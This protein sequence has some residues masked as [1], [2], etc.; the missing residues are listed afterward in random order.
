MSPV[1][2]TPDS[3]VYDS[4]EAM[5]E[6]NA[7]ALTTTCTWGGQSYNVGDTVCNNGDEYKCG[8]GGW[9]KDGKKC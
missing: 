6:A 3:P 1:E 7:D 4:E 8:S 2:E 9:Y 5:Q